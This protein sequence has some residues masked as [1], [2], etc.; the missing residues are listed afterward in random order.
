MRSG[1]ATFRIAV[2]QLFANR[3]ENDIIL[4]MSLWLFK[5]EPGEYSFADLMRDK[6]TVWSGVANNTALLHLRAVAKGDLVLI[7]HT[8]SEKQIVGIAQLASAAYP[9]P[10]ESNEKFLVVDLKA[11][12]ALKKPVAL[13]RMKAEKTFA[14]WELVRISRLSVMPV[15]EKIWKRIEVLSAE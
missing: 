7:Y 2:A 15:P 11:K 10:N 9:D 12:R 8:G 5:T 13:A 1:D 4:P 3:P 6:K 14:D